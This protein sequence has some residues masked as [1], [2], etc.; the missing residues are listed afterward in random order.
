MTIAR[1]FPRCDTPG[2]QAGRRIALWIVAVAVSVGFWTQSI[3]AF[4]SVCCVVGAVAEIC[5][6]YFDIQL[7]AMRSEGDEE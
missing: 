4:A 5:R 1:L 7:R 3:W 2:A 6:T